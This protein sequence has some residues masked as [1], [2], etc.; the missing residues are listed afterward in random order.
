MPWAWSR[1]WGIVKSQNASGVQSPSGGVPL[2]T[3][4]VKCS[5]LMARNFNASEI[6]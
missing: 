2:S 4:S 3:A 1:H 5:N 6:K